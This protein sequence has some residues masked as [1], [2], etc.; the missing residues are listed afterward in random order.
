MGGPVW[1]LD[2]VAVRGG[3]SDP[4]FLYIEGDGE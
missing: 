4:V 2:P 1:E 3:G